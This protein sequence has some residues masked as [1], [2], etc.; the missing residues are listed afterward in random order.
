MPSLRS[1]LQDQDRGHLFMIADLWRIDL[2]APNF[3]EGLANLIE[4]LPDTS[5]FEEVFVSLPAEA[6]TALQ[7]L[8][9][10]LGRI[11][12]NQFLMMYGEIRQVGAGKRDREKL[13]R[14]PQTISE[15]LF[16]RGLIAFG[17]FS[18]EA[19]LS[20]QIYLPDELLP[21]VPNSEHATAPSISRIVS[22][23]KLSVFKEV[24][25]SIIDHATTLLAAV[26]NQFS[27]EKLER[28][29]DRWDIPNRFLYSLLQSAKLIDAKGEPVSPR[30]KLFL[31]SASGMALHQLWQIWMGS[32]NHHD[33]KH[34][35][36]IYLEGEW[37]SDPFVPRNKI[38][39]KLLQLDNGVWWSIPAVI[40][41]FYTHDPAFLRQS[42]EFD[43]WYL[44]DK[45]TNQ[46]LR[47]FEYWHQVEGAYLHALIV[48]PLHWLGV[49]D[50]ASENVNDPISAF[51]FSEMSKSLLND[52][53]PIET[54]E[55]EKHIFVDAGLG[56]LI[57]DNFPRDIRYQF[58]RFLTWDGKKRENYAY[59]ISPTSLTNALDQGLKVSQLI[60]LMKKY[61]AHQIP[62]SVET[63]LNRWT[64]FGAQSRLEK[65]TILR[66]YNPEALTALRDSN[67]AR[68]LG[69]TL[70]PTSIIINPGAW[71]KVVAKLA[72]LGYLSEINFDNHE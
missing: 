38:I 31:E 53:A 9:G 62:A 66:L 10:R 5:L 48:G 70:G 35:L 2:D 30:I 21:L 6:K 45:H 71:Q 28:I 12:K 58:A 14:V 68:F 33:L 52:L 51:R 57:P 15:W 54:V 44:R 40:Q 47:G 11:P 23:S 55:A 19:G 60:S 39:N 34:L 16:F 65:V 8:K 43:S 22:E 17:T 26:R 20:E 61:T 63:S 42:G 24:N 36:P 27:D 25:Y 50:L 32:K 1:S 59:R 18:T 29:S 72:E 41:W 13:Y 7:N 56:I 69:D 37:E 64:Q 3:Q 67:A 4:A 49:V 46:Y